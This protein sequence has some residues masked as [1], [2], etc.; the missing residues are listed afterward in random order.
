[1]SILSNP[2]SLSSR[3]RQR[4]DIELCTSQTMGILASTHLRFVEIL[5]LPA[6]SKRAI[7]GDRCR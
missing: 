2:D 3:R 7:E 1:M 4:Y 5:G 6:G